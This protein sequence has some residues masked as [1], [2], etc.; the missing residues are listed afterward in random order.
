[1]PSEATAGGVAL[2]LRL[3]KNLTR[4]YEM[5]SK[6]LL[7]TLFVLLVLPS[8]VLAQEDENWPPLSYLRSDYK[9]VNVVLHVRAER[10]EVV[11]R[12]GGYE[13]WR[14][15]AVVI[16]S[17]K[18]KFKK[19]DA[20]VYSHGA[21][22]GFKAELFTGEKIIFLLAERDKDRTLHYSVLENSTLAYTPDRILKLRKI[23]R[24]SARRPRR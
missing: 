20:I 2:G 15:N 17:L 12:I 1:M 14:I 13:T 18:G 7:K 6:L 10:A 5:R 9:E 24:S 19:G 3:T 8:C 16:E 21:E 22:T 23:K 11:Y 4:G